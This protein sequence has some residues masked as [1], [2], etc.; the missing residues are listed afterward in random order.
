MD[1]AKK[2][3]G[4]NSKKMVNVIRIARFDLILQLFDCDSNR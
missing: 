1:P 4:R 2:V 3:P